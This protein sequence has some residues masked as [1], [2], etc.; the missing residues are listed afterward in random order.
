[1]NVPLDRMFVS[2]ALRAE[3]ALDHSLIA[4][5][6]H[7]GEHNLGQ[8]ILASAEVA[9]ALANES[10]RASLARATLGRRSA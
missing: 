7:G 1:M 3:R 6:E 10:R 4:Y 5:A 9:A 8:A 2:E